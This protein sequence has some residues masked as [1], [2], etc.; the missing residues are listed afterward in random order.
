MHRNK[1]GRDIQHY[2]PLMAIFF[3]GILGFLFFPYDK[4]FQTAVVIA[5][6][7]GYVSWGIVHHYI[8]GNLEAYVV[9]EYASIALLGI[10]ITISLLYF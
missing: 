3:V 7:C 2:L 9:A 6:S 8:H 10:I 5:V 1:I 4:P